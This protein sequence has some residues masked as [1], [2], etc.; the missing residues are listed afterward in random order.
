MEYLMW[1]KTGSGEADVF[2]VMLRNEELRRFHLHTLA[3][4][5][6]KYIVQETVVFVFG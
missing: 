1:S 4:V 5:F 2:I 3:R 6:C